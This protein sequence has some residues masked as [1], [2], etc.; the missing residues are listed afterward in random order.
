MYQALYRKYRPKDFDSVVGQDHIVKTLKNSIK[1]HTFSHAYMF[2]GSRGIGKTTVSK[3]FARNVNCLNSKDGLACGKCSN[4]KNSFSNEC[5]DII[6]ID[7]ASNNGV[8]D[9]R[10]LK[11]KVSLVPAE[12]TYKVYIIDEVHMLSIEAFN[13]LLKTLEEP[14]SHAIFILA[15]T[16]PQ[17]VPETIISRC[18]C[19]SFQ[20]ISPEIIVNKLVEICKNENIK[21]DSDVLYNI[22]VF[23][24]GGLR[25]SIGLL[26]KLISYNP[27]NITMDDFTEI[28]GIISEGKIKEFTNYVFSGDVK[29]VLLS[30]SDFEN[31]GKNLVQIYI[32]LL[33]YLRN[34]IVD[35][36]LNNGPLDYSIDLL[37]KL[38]FIL[39][40]NMFDIKN[41][42]N[43]RVF[44]EMIVLKF[45][46]DNSLFKNTVSNV[47][48]DVNDFISDDIKN[49]AD[50]SVIKEDVLS[51]DKT[52]VIITNDVVTN[53]SIDLDNNI[54]K[55]VNLSDIMKV[56]INN[57][58]AMANKKLLIEEKN[59]FKELKD[60]SFDQKIGYIVCSLLDSNLR[61]VSENEMIISFD[62]KSTV[63]QNLLILSSIEDVYN[64]ITN[65]N[66]K[67]AIVSDDDWE[68]IKNEYI[69]NLKNN[70]S[71][72]IEEEPD[73]IFENLNND[74]II[75][76]SAINLFGDIVEVE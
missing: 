15:T 56:R 12:L 37:Q 66:K 54:R 68:N 42:D 34:I 23:S 30:I 48:S 49:N 4:C 17:K 67:I 20:R 46:S 45:I 72:K 21:I 59:K 64:K 7:A 13:A 22:A 16:D 32:Q 74:D 61:A 9:I 51:N 50:V 60:Y 31:D 19:F 40:E 14:P 36:F 24:E 52:D 70:V 44:F 76:S 63:D 28:N 43:S 55:I 6:E 10:N 27:N 5:V 75:T 29:R 25:D 2:F 38:L 65:S 62:L 26:D 53:S 58:L 11:S 47:S 57:T 35:Y 71:Y 39:N 1:N 8:D 3:I 69:L 33:N 73:E 18:Q 41:S